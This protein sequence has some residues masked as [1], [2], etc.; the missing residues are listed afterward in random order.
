MA[1]EKNVTVLIT[2]PEECRDKLR[3]LAAEAMLGNPKKLITGAGL[4][5]KIVC[6]FLNSE[7]LDF[8]T[9][10]PQFT[11]NKLP[12]SDLKDH[13]EATLSTGGKNDE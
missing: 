9:I 11:D 6:S 3:R 4:A 12:P 8:L 7:H 13:D 5:G 2:I 1:E 10:D